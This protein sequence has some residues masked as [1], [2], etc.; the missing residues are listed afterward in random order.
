MNLYESIDRRKSVRSYAM[1]P[2]ADIVLN[3]IQEFSDKTERLDD[4]IGMKTEIISNFSGKKLFHGYC[5]VKAPYYLVLYSEKSEGYQLNAGYVAEQIVL[6]ITLKNIGSCYLGM[7]TPIL[8]GIDVKGY[9]PVIVIAF[10]REMNTVFK[11]RRN[12]RRHSLKSLCVFKENGNEEIMAIL[13]A[14]A[15]APSSLNS[16]PW[17]FVVYN[18]R[19]HIFL[20]KS[21]GIFGKRSRL[22]IFNIGIALSHMMMAAEEMWL[23]SS[24]IRLENIASNS[25]YENE[26]VISFILNK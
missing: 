4:T 3:H 11:E 15:K 20:K 5:N 17:R 6:Y 1:E 25:K 26:Y 14:A 7:C 21:G 18:N 22:E 13:S 8:P 12:I 24:I 16:Q 10:G 23:E 19:I 2:L 9:E